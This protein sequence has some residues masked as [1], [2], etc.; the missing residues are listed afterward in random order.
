MTRLPTTDAPAHWLDGLPEREI[1]D[2]YADTVAR[3]FPAFE[4][5]D[6]DEARIDM[7]QTLHEYDPTGVIDQTLV[8]VISPVTATSA[9]CTTSRRT[10]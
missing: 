4:V 3:R 2:I 9:S 5:R 7:A 6:F 1:Y 8:D 10:P